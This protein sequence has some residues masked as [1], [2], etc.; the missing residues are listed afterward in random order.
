LLDLDGIDEKKR[1]LTSTGQGIG[2]ALFG[3]SD[4]DDTFTDFEIDIVGGEAM[5]KFAADTYLF[6]RIIQLTNTLHK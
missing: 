2:H 1:K 3:S 6:F 4:S 5:V